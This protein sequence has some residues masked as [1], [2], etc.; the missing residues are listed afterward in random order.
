MSNVE[1]RSEKLLRFKSTFV[2][3][4]RLEIIEQ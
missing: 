2:K 1:C 4:S 3:L